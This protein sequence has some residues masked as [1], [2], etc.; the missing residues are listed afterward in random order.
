LRR[1]RD[2]P[3]RAPLVPTVAQQLDAESAV[4]PARDQRDVAV[5][6]DRGGGLSRRAGEKRQY[7]GGQPTRHP[8]KVDARFSTSDSRDAASWLPT[9]A[10]GEI[11]AF[12]RRQVA[13]A[14]AEGA[15]FMLLAAPAREVRVRGG[16]RPEVEHV[17]LGILYDPA[18]G[19]CR[20]LRAIG[21]D[22]GSVRAE[23]TKR[24]GPGRV[25]E[26]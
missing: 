3:A 17:L 9:N 18:G 12:E 1:P 21:V 23:L 13:H 4:P 6:R 14:L 11:D 2:A 16:R 7:D 19:A 22:P 8:G 5:A 15:S 25:P 24:L 10:R 20:T 26:V